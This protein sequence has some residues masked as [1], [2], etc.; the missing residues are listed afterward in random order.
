MIAK[1]E[2]LK[3]LI[4]NYTSA[5]V[6]YSGGIDS[7]LLC[8]FA[9]EVLA[10]KFLA[11]ITTSETLTEEEIQTAM[12]IAKKYDWPLLKIKSQ[13]LEEE[14]FIQNNADKCKWCKDIKIREI[15]KIAIDKGFKEI[16]TGDNL[17]DLKDYR[18]GFKHAQTLGVKSPFI[19]ANI[20]KQEIRTISKEIGLPNYEKPS[21]PCLASRIPYGIRITK[22][23]LKK[24]EAAEFFIK[25]LGYNVVRVRHEENTAKIEIEKEHQAH[26]TSTHA[27]IVVEKL[28]EI[29]YT[30]VVLDL[31]GYKIGNLNK[32]LKTNEA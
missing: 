27:E 24:V 32:V 21:T 26:F 2:N 6:A 10:D 13:E 7:T 31:Q 12:D 16:I 14:I 30:Y 15:K 25:S 8:Y 4:K 28:K 19:D 5:I 17:D 9:N 22:E 20:N 11:V 29:G 1:I 18:P 23:N 3:D